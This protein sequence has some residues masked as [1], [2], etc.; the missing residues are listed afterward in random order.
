MKVKASLHLH[1]SE[2]EEDSIII[3][4]SLFELIDRLAALDFKVMASTGHSN[5]VCRSDHFEY[6][7]KKGILLI[8]GIEANIEG[9]KHM[10]ILNGGSDAEKVRSF[11]D[12]KRFKRRHPESFIIAP[13]PNHGAHSITLGTLR[14]MADIIDAVEHSWYYSRSIDQ[15]RRTGQVSGELGLPFIVTSDA[16]VLDY[17]DTDYAVIEADKLTVDAVFGA[18]RNGKF[19][20]RTR[21]KN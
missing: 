5:G 13:H 8:A 21:P 7:K 11:D 4:Y 19:V 9:H 2:D 20:N 18:I 6:A 15:N 14:K 1:S 16:H 3:D 17:L 12:L 10:L